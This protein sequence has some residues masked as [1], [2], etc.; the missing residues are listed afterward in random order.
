MGVRTPRQAK[1]HAQRGAAHV[2]VRTPRQAKPHTQR[3][4]RTWA[5]ALHGGRNHI[6]SAECARPRAQQ[7][8]SLVQHGAI[9]RQPHMTL[10]Q[11]LGDG[12]AVPHDPLQGEV[13]ADT[14][15]VPLKDAVAVVVA[16]AQ[17][18]L[19][20]VDERYLS[21]PVQDIVGRQ[22]AVDHARG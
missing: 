13:F 2:G 1:P 21:F 7:P 18:H 3:G 6:P 8:N 9:G 20:E 5:C 4:L 19:G 14:A 10:P 22:V 16:L 17:S 15:H 12:V 11:A